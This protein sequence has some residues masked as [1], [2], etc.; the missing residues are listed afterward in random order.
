MKIDENPFE[1]LVFVCSI[2]K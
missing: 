2:C 1:N